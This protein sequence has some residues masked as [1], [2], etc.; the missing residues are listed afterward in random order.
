MQV[1]IYDKPSTMNVPQKTTVR[2]NQ[3][4]NA[5]ESQTDKK[6]F[7]D[8]ISYI[9]SLS[10]QPKNLTL[11]ETSVNAEVHGEFEVNE[12]TKLDTRTI[13]NKLSKT[14]ET[15]LKFRFSAEN[16]GKKNNYEF[17]MKFNLSAE[18]VYK[19]NT[20][21]KKEDL[22]NFINKVMQ[23]VT[24]LIRNKKFDLNS[25]E[26]DPED[27]E[28]LMK[29]TDPKGNKSIL[30]LIN[31]LIEMARL[32]NTENK[33]AIDVVYHPTRK[34]EQIREIEINESLTTNMTAKLTKLDE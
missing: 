15:I 1:K 11:S 10:V 2:I 9:N 20:Q 33:D 21:L 28:E 12:D 30:L 18:S 22:G 24:E 29:Y 14:M 23:K 34:K 3:N 4:Y 8:L 25:I 26:W 6:S 27:L 13:Y 17:E 16:E 19:D 32:Q 31:S 5:A 7:S